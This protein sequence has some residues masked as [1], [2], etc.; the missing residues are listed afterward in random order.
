[1]FELYKAAENMLLALKLGKKKDFSLDIS[2]VPDL[3][4]SSDQSVLKDR[5]SYKGQ[6]HPV[7][8]NIWT[9]KTWV[10]EDVWYAM[11]HL[12]KSI[13][14]EG[15]KLPEETIKSLLEST[16]R[17]EGEIDLTRHVPQIEKLSEELYKKIDGA[18][19]KHKEKI[20][21]L[22][23]EILGL[24]KKTQT[25]NEAAIKNRQDAL[26]DLKTVSRD[27]AKVV[28][29]VYVKSKNSEEASEAISKGVETL[30]EQQVTEAPEPKEKPE[31]SAEKT[32]FDKKDREYILQEAKEYK[33]LPK[34]LES[35]KDTYNGDMLNELAL[36]GSGGLKDLVTY[37]GDD[38]EDLRQKLKT[39]A[40]LLQGP[41]SGLSKLQ[42]SALDGVETY[43][44]KAKD[45]DTKVFKEKS[46]HKYTQEVLDFIK[47]YMRK[48]DRNVVVEQL[49]FAVI[50]GASA[51]K[52]ENFPKVTGLVQG[53][54]RLGIKSVA[55][56]FSDFRKDLSEEAK[57]KI[58]PKLLVFKKDDKE[59]ELTQEHQESFNKLKAIIKNNTV[60]S[61][62]SSE[63]GI[64][65]EDKEVA[66][67]Y[68]SKV[69]EKEPLEEVF[70][71]LSPEELKKQKDEYEEEK[72]SIKKIK[73]VADYGF[74]DNEAKKI[75][76][77]KEDMQGISPGNRNVPSDKWTQKD[78]ELYNS[79][80]KEV[81]NLD[82]SLGF[83]D[84]ERKLLREI[85]DK[86]EDKR[87]LTDEEKD[88]LN[89]FNK[90]KKEPRERKQDVYQPKKDVEKEKTDK[91]KKIEEDTATIKKV[92]DLKNRMN[93]Y[94]ERRWPMTFREKDED[95][96]SEAQS[97]LRALKKRLTVNTDRAEY[98]ELEKKFDDIVKKKASSVI[99]DAYESS[100]HYKLQKVSQ[101][102]SD[103]LL[104]A[105]L[106]DIARILKSVL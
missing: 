40:P 27:I 74:S 36:A 56:A 4:G 61:E 28:K 96:I 75:L 79:Y 15:K 55:S 19:P 60:T 95:S 91:E 26:K 94:E 47:D 33:S 7:S 17:L 5:G 13:T 73:E 25:E 18:D 23:E 88:L 54:N 52:E 53:W 39:K 46:F 65:E 45:I 102:T 69:K 32:K 106:Q 105:E 77:L 59:I 64:T 29:R 82:K 70:K 8:G 90:K 11:Q 78:K 66:D 20:K 97:E 57:G 37:L 104:R 103:I 38:Y 68:K 98:E 93:R 51:A 34:L 9:G 83:N 16:K 2:V 101:M 21:S 12:P 85:R 10:T 87:K 81:E 1:M 76:E 22:K 24:W 71:S 58:D 92:E 99:K 6:Q 35:L 3:G 84:E 67:Q 30:P 62:D 49:I 72:I 89:A 41:G 43:L 31:F 42:E 86:K 50:T 80:W 48:K 63:V 100:I 14:S 44:K